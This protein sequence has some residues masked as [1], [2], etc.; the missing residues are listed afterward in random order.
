CRNHGYLSGEVYT[1]PECGETTEVY[2][3]ITGYYRPVQHWNDGK[4]QEYKQ[5]KEYDPLHSVLKHNGVLNPDTIPHPAE[6]AAEPEPMQAKIMLFATK[7]CP[8]C[9]VA[10]SMLE[11]AGIDFEKVYVEDNEDL[12]RSYEL[13]QAPTLVIDNA[14][15]VER[16]V[17]VPN[18]KKFIA[19]AKETVHA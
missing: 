19:S 6:T 3:R 2:S 1:C 8:N 17:S 12:A 4:S 5:R 15:S 9:K 16:F 13:R 10:V 14:G 11:K 18:I 7:T